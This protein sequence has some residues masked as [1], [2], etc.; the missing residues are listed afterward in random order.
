MSDIKVYYC[1]STENPGDTHRISPAPSITIN[2]EIYYANDNV[3][4]YNYT[5]TL[6]GYA[7]SIRKDLNAGSV[8]YGIDKTVDHI[9]KIREIFNFNGG[10]LYIKRDNTNI[11]IAKGATV[12]QISFNESDNRWI[13]Y[14]P[15]TIQLT[16]NEVDMPGCSNNSVISCNSSLFHLNQD[17]SI[18]A[19]NLIDIT[20]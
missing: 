9:G 1:K 18:I 6:N 14:A 20:K 11:L 17:K 3:F 13:N 12:Q 16:F 5:I 15:F 8:N 19:D 10:N 2:P 7:N 4:G